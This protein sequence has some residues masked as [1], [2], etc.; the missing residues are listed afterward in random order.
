MLFKLSHLRMVPLGR[1]KQG[2]MI[3]TGGS[4]PEKGHICHP[5]STEPHRDL[6]HEYYGPKGP[7]G[8]GSNWWKGAVLPFSPLEAN[9]VVPHK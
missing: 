3:P 8:L 7:I 9:G 1:E 6:S 2:G 5:L 4:Q